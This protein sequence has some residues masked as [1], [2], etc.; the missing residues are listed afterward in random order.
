MAQVRAL[1]PDDDVSELIALSRIFF[2]EYE[3][4]HK[5]FFAIDQLSNDD[6]INYFTRLMNSEDGRTFIAVE[7]GKTVGYITVFAREQPGFYKIKRVG[8]VSGLMVHPDYR[9]RGIATQLLNQTAAFLHENGVQYFTVYT[10]T[11]NRG[12]LEFYARSGLTPL[13]TTMIG[14]SPSFCQPS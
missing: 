9:R 10:A 7:E 8:A 3:G 5:G 12:A 11:A 2:Q 6:I 4:H 14:G 13:Y 1:Q